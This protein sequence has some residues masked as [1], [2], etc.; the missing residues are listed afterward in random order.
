MKITKRQLRRIIK[1]ELSLLREGNPIDPPGLKELLASLN[2]KGPQ[3]N[4]VADELSMAY[5]HEGDPQDMKDQVEEHSGGLPTSAP[6]GDPD[7]W[8]N[9]P[10]DVYQ[11]IWDLYEKNRADYQDP[12][13]REVQIS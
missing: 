2:V 9:W 13:E 10:V 4:A 3:F 6:Q 7:R 12:Y 1:E 11:E 5:S 8:I